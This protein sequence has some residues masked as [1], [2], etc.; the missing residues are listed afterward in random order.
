MS[1]SGTCT[2]G[3]PLL[4]NLELVACINLTMG[5]SSS[6]WFIE[7][8]L[9]NPYDLESRWLRGAESARVAAAWIVRTRDL[10]GYSPSR[11]QSLAD[12]Q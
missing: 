10:Q 9:I 6:I 3:N 7:Y 11:A 5:V 8:I 2:A 4:I 12:Q 1:L